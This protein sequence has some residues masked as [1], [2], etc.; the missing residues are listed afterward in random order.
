MIQWQYW[1][2]GYSSHIRR[3]SFSSMSSLYASKTW[4]IKPHHKVL[5]RTIRIKKSDSFE[6]GFLFC[7]KLGL[8]PKK[9]WMWPFALS[10]SPSK[11]ILRPITSIEFLEYSL[12]HQLFYSIAG[13]TVC[14]AS[15]F[16]D[17]QHHIKICTYLFKGYIVQVD[18]VVNGCELFRNFLLLSFHKI[19]GDCITVVCLKQF[20]SLVFQRSFLP[21]ESVKLTFVFLLLVGD[22]FL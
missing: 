17:V 19:K 3:W 18:F 11:F 13:V 14:L 8:H 2:A 5:T 15:V 7:S 6:Q 1:V 12:I 4:L 22:N 10:A 9:S 21:F 16:H 20:L